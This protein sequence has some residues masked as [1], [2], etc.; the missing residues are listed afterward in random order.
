MAVLVAPDARLLKLN[1]TTPAEA[2]A[3]PAKTISAAETAA[4][5]TCLVISTPDGKPV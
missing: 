2:E 3:L 4:I 1:V 5:P